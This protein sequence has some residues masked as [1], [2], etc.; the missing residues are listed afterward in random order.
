[1]V[2][3]E[4]SHRFSVGLTNRSDCAF[5]GWPCHH[6]VLHERRI[7]DGVV[8]DG[9]SRA[10]ALAVGP[11][12]QHLDVVI[13]VGIKQRGVDFLGQL[14]VLGVG[15]LGPIQR[16]LRDG[17]FFFVDDALAGLV[18]I[19]LAYL[20]IIFPL[21][22]RSDDTDFGADVVGG[23]DLARPLHGARCSGFDFLFHLLGGD[24]IDRRALIDMLAA[25]R[26]TAR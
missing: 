11:Q 16:D 22:L 23:S 15:L 8:A 7:V 13:A 6:R 20:S 18:E 19:H 10:E 5:H 24:H 1:M 12:H 26:P 2:G 14:L 3:L 21:R 25:F 4:N 17:T 9:M